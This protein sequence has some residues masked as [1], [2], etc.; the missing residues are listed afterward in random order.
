MSRLFSRLALTAVTIAAVAGVSTLARADEYR[1]VELHIDFQKVNFKDPVAVKKLYSKLK[2]AA[3]Y[4][5]EDEFR[6]AQLEACVAQK[7]TLAVAQVGREQLSVMQEPQYLV[8]HPIEL[9]LNAPKA[10]H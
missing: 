7:L 4:L 3:Y 10:A 2:G 8:Q 1:D 6:D 9:T 5:C